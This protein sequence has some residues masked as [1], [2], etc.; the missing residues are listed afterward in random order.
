M[1]TTTEKAGFKAVEFMRKTRAELSEFYQRDKA[2][3]HTE[4]NQAAT[5]FLTRRAKRA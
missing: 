4:L 5:D 1:K 2:Q 3:F